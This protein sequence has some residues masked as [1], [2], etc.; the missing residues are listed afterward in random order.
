ML[1]SI[2]LRNFKSFRQAD[3]SLERLAVFVG[4]NASGKTS[5]LERSST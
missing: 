3:I 2:E 1:Y 4:A 5:V